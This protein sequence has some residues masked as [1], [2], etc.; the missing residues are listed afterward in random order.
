MYTYIL[1]CKIMSI[2][3]ESRLDET[4]KTHDVIELG[5]SVDDVKPKKKTKYERSELRLLES[6]EGGQIY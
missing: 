1:V 6:L 4:G 2:E 3:L 5:Y